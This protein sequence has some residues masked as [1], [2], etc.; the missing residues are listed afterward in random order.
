MSETWA[1][2]LLLPP[3][4][5]LIGVKAWTSWKQR[6]INLYNRLVFKLVMLIVRIRQRVISIQGGAPASKITI[7][8]E[9]KFPDEEDLPLEM[10][11]E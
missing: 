7:T 8:W 11:G 4:F 10:T 6:R 9:R 1:W 5:A 3:V 2:L